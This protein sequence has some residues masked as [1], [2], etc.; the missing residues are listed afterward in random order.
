MRN[1][2]LVLTV[3]VSMGTVGCRSV[4]RHEE[5]T[6]EKWSADRARCQYGID[7]EQIEEIKKD[8]SAPIP[9]PRSPREWKT[10]MTTLGWDS[11]YG[12]RFGR[13]WGR[14]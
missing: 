4:W 8:P 2:F 10:C 6:P 13:Q 7:P 5:A 14:E 3:A 11:G 12:F 9:R 1:W